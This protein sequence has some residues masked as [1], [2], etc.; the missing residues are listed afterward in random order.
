MD[1]ALSMLAGMGMGAGLMYMLDP[2][3]GRR[4]RAHMRDK[5]VS[6]AHEAQ[7][8]AEVVGRDMRNRA[9]GL[10][11]GDLSVLAGGK[12]ALQ[13]PLQGS[14][15]PSGRALL[16]G[17]GAGLFLYGLTRNAPASCILGTLGTVLA[18]EGLTNARF[19][20]IRDAAECLA[21]RAREV[22]GSMSLGAHGEE[23]AGT[24]RQQD[25]SQPATAGA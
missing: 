4:R 15:S 19:E 5:A 16:T 10:A 18:A 9:R 23:G 14:W 20:D 22:A 21:N 8:A 24:G 1:R 2:R 6:L 7:D 3:L 13:H 11:S 17:L 12:R 25:A